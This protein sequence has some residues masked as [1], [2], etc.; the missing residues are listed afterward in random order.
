M[1]QLGEIQFLHNAHAMDRNRVLNLIYDRQ[2]MTD[3]C[4]R[5]MCIVVFVARNGS[6]II[7]LFVV[8]T[9]SLQF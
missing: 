6:R 8:E 4:V 5:W 7:N 2:D 3:F 9:K 1:F